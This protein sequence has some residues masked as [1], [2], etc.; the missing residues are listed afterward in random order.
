MITVE[1]LGILRYWASC[2]I[3][4]VFRLS[5]VESSKTESLKQPCQTFHV[6]IVATPFNLPKRKKTTETSK[7][8]EQ[9]IQ[10][11]YHAEESI[12][13]FPQRGANR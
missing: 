9:M 12:N 10:F 11:K 6:L 1:K 5:S 3:T 8:V 4:F 7:K 13:N 2:W